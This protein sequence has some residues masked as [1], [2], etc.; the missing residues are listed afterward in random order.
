MARR[1]I[2]LFLLMVAP[3][4]AA[5]AEPDPPRLAEGSVEAALPELV[6]PERPGLVTAVTCPELDAEAIAQST[7]CRA[8]LDGASVTVAVEIDEVGVVSAEVAEPL[9]DFGAVEEQ[10]A[11]RLAADLGID[12]PVV[13]CDRAVAISRAGTE[14]TCVADRDGD[15]ITFL[16][17]LVGA[18]G[19]FTV[20]IA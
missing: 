6:W 10:L 4:V 18:D 2:P 11:A 16:V 3:M 14:T 9:F 15:T 7:V 5:C 13:S 17:R 12:A 20:E 19:A 1:L 8:T